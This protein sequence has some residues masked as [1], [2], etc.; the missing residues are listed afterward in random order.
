MQS[1]LKRTDARPGRVRSR[2]LLLVISLIFCCLAGEATVRI[3]F[4]RETD[5][6]HLR[7][8]QERMEIGALIRPSPDPELFYELKPGLAVP[9]LGATVHTDP[10]GSFRTSGAQDK[11]KTE[12]PSIKIA[13][14]GDSTSFGWGVDH[15]ETYAEQLRKR[16]E[17]H[18]GRPV[19]VRN[20]SVPGY[21]THQE[22]ACFRKRVAPWRP[23]LL[24][25]HYDHNDPDPTNIAHPGYMEPEYG[26]NC[27]RSAFVKL[28]LRRTRAMKNRGLR[29][30]RDEDPGNPDKSLDL[31]K[32]AGALY[33]RHLQELREMAEE[34]DRRDIPV[35]A[36]IFDAWIPRVHD[37]AGDPH[38]RLL[39][40][41]LVEHLER[42][43]FH[44]LDLYPRYQEMMWKR[45]WKNLRPFWLSVPLGDCHPN[46][47]GHAFIASEIFRFIDLNEKLEGELAGAAGKGRRA[48]L[49]EPD[50]EPDPGSDRH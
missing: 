17:K 23:D 8:Q 2:I 39:H 44:T 30:F 21:N 45:G 48:G 11:T 10:S 16:L 40:Q 33:D 37:P 29:I 27:F 49:P 25:L 14:L 46:R 42:S 41:G 28:I 43:G 36:V 9:W 47:A 18:F 12:T 32:Y 24:I 34:A 13:V 3:F 38:Y 35:L 50:D 22:L 6:L 7:S 15:A 19:E 5:T 20:Y 4:W 31:C 1:P 26:D